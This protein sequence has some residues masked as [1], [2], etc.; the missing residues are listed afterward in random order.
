[1]H[2]LPPDKTQLRQPAAKAPARWLQEDADLVDRA[3]EEP[4]LLLDRYSPLESRATGGFGVVEVCW[5]TRLQRRVAIKRIS[6]VDS[7]T[8]L[9]ASSAEEAVAE[10]RTASM[11]AHPNIVTLFDFESD[12]YYAYLVME[13]VD[14]LSLAEL[15]QRVEG[16]VLTY[17]EV[18]HVLVSVSEALAFAHDNGVLHL[19][20]KPSN[21][22]IDRS[23][24]V[25]VGDF[26][27]AALTSAAGY[28]GARGGTVGYMPPE[29]ITG[30]L[31][32]ERSDLF[33]LAVVCWQALTGA[34]PF[35]AG[36]AGESLALIQKGPRPRLSKSNPELAGLVETALTDAMS[37][38]P[39]QRMA[40]VGQFGQI[41]AGEL[42][43]SNAGH[44]SLQ[45]LLAQ[46][47]D[48]DRTAGTLPALPP[49]AQRMPWLSTLTLRAITAACCGWLAWTCMSPLS[50]DVWWG[51]GAA[52]AICAL[53]AAL[54]P[55]L[56]G[57]LSL[58]G[59]GAS[60]LLSLPAQGA[61]S[62][63]MLA[64][65]MIAASC[66]WW[67]LAGRK[68]P[69]ST[70]AFLLPAALS[71]PYA[72]APLAGW[73]MRPAASLATGSLSYIFAR[74]LTL[75]L[76]AHFDL[77]LVC[78][79]LSSLVLHPSFWVGVG[80]VGL[81]ALLCSALSHRDSTSLAI[82]AQI[83]GIALLAFSSAVAGRVEN[84]GIWQAPV[85]G[86]LALAV[87]CSVSVS[88]AILLFGPPDSGVEVD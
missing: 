53:C 35:A 12:D 66:S 5:D 36:T 43:D 83:L 46:L 75:V 17:D 23:G 10:A 85:W 28:G 42:G 18:A 76:A 56:G 30:S 52:V 73:A 1:M 14:G 11:L 74:I 7:A 69:A 51:P 19:D 45:Q 26:G 58:I 67:A 38:D 22:L 57:L 77:N 47:S 81:S 49:L 63:M 79:S 54:L 59:I 37:Q 65:A 44:L 25:K 88:L 50:Q 2:D 71:S 72:A 80:G 64:G 34:N 78:M 86:E 6:L 13:Y 39:A 48:D 70:A 31:V 8:G 68:E 55:Q 27:M 84:G 4:S 40:D 87:L 62:G 3:D 32:D 82:V 20:I 21:I 16:G 60:L 15:L 24:T 9:M 33:S 41:V 61:A 29:Q